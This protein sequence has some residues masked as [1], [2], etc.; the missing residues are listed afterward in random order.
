[1]QND[2]SK[3]IDKEGGIVARENT[4]VSQDNSPFMAIVE[5]KNK[6]T[7]NKIDDSPR[8]G[9]MQRALAS[10]NSAC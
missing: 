3:K 6:N 7:C 9:E 1:M 4:S 8:W 5:V 2:K 10:I